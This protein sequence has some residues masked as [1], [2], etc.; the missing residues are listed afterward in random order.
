[1]A[2]FDAWAANFAEAVT[3]LEL[4]PDGSGYRMHTRFAKF[5]NLPE[6]LSMF[7]TFADVQTADMLNLPR[8]MVAG[9]KPQIA[10]AAGKRAAQSVH[11][12][13]HRPRR[14]AAHGAGRSFGRQHAQDHRRRPQG[15]A[16]YAAGRS[17]CR[18]GGRYEAEP[19]RGPRS[20]KVWADTRSDAVH[21]ACVLRSFD[22]GPLRSTP[23]A[24]TS[25]TR[26][27]RSLIDSGVP[28]AEI[29]FIHDADTDAEKKLLFDAVNAGRVRILIGSTEKMGAGTNVQQRLA[30]LHHLDAPWRPAR[31]RAARGANS[32]AGQSERRGARYT[33]T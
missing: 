22:A 9:G 33:A 10:A 13:A 17:P 31:Y 16:R 8:P 32:A 6:L 20:G 1:M 21:A 28:E 12:N 27:G 15:R 29:A 4:A 23:A 18:A 7:R 26:C 14:A 2:H 30:A 25:T 24:S 11:Q 3:A 5:I 19:G